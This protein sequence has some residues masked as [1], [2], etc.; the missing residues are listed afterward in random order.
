MRFISTKGFDVVADVIS[1]MTSKPRTPSV[2]QHNFFFEKYY[3][4]Q[5]Y[6]R[7]AAQKQREA[8]W[9]SSKQ[10]TNEPKPSQEETQLEEKKKKTLHPVVLDRKRYLKSAGARAVSDTKG[11]R[12]FFL[13][14]FFFE[15]HTRPAVERISIMDRRAE[16]I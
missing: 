9:A 2:Q 16:D 10:R 3:Y 11:R 8:I 13:G 14:L 7:Y 5:I 1:I 6:R 4:V 12:V 15:R